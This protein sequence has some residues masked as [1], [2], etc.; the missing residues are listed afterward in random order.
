MIKYYHAVKCQSQNDYWQNIFAYCLKEKIENWKKTTKNRQAH[1]GLPL[2]KTTIK[3]PLSPKTF[4]LT[5]YYT[6]FC[7]CKLGSRVL[8][9][10]EEGIHLNPKKGKKKRGTSE[11]KKARIRGRKLAGAVYENLASSIKKDS[12]VPKAAADTTT[13]NRS[14]FLNISGKLAHIKFLYFKMKW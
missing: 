11:G 14:H 7:S 12:I 9:R 2:W 1:D 8:M 4:V 3:D 13:L 10:L 6:F 5:S